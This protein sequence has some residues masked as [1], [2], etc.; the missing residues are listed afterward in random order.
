MSK[1]YN[2]SVSRVPNTGGSVQLTVGT[3]GGVAN[4]AHQP[5]STPCK[6]VWIMPSADTTRV[7]IGSACTGTT[8]GMRLASTTI[9]VMI[10]IDDINKLYF[11][12]S[13]NN[14]TIDILWRE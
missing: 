5:T 3:T 11:Y 13:S 4:Q 12:G 9:P 10:E 1:F 6:R 14:E 7:N 8:I 2:T